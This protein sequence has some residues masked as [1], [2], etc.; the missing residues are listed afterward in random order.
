[1]H[2]KP[3]SIAAMHSPEPCSALS[4]KCNGYTGLISINGN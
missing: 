2:I 1:M 4:L 3:S